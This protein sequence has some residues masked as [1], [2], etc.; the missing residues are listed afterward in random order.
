MLLPRALAGFLADG[1]IKPGASA[2]ANPCLATV[3][4]T[5]ACTASYVPDQKLPY[6]IQ[7]NLGIQ[8]VFAKNYTLKSAIWGPAAY[9]WMC[10]SASI[11][12]RW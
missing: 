6:S 11:R 2:G 7:W 10:S 4:A 8:Q 5:R 1:G 9:I 12:C 3:L